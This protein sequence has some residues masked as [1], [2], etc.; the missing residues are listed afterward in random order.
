MENYI[1]NNTKQIVCELTTRDCKY[2]WTLHLHFLPLYEKRPNIPGP[3]AAVLCWWHHLEP[4]W[5][6][7][8][9]IIRGGFIENYLIIN[10]V[11]MQE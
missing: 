11:D 2:T 4:A 9:F 8:N 7:T 1:R 6:K 10:S 3:D 5:T